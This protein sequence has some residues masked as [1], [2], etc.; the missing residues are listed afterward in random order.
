MEYGLI[1]DTTIQ[2]IADGLREKGIMPK[3]YNGIVPFNFKS[4]NATSLKDPTPTHRIT[5]EEY[6][7]ISIAAAAKIEVIVDVG[8]YENPE[9]PSYADAPIQFYFGNINA[10][11][12]VYPEDNAPIFISPTR[13]DPRQYTCV[14]PKNSFKIGIREQDSTSLDWVALTVKAYALNAEG[15]RIEIDTEETIRYAPYEIVEAINN[16]PPLPP[17]SAFKITGNCNNRFS[18]DGWNWFIN[19]YGDKITTE[20]ITAAQSMFSNNTLERLPFIINLS[21]SCSTDSMFKGC[22]NL[23]EL[24][25][26]NNLS[27]A[28]SLF[29]NCQKLTS[30]N[31]NKFTAIPSNVQFYMAFQS[32]YTL[33][34][35]GNILDNIPDVAPG[36]SIYGFYD[37]FKNCYSLEEATNLPF[38]Y[39]T[40]G[41]NYAFG[42]CFNYCCSIREITFRNQVVTAKVK[43]CTLDLNIF[44]GWIHNA[45]EYIN[46]G[47]SIEKKVTDDASY[48]A[49]K[50]DPEWWSDVPEYSRYNHDSAV[51][52]INSLPDVSGIGIINTIKFK[53]VSGSATDGGAINTL[54][55]EEIAVA[56]AKGWTVTLV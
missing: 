6:I 39:S 26:I 56:T 44:V 13:N 10:D 36:V 48:Q 41:G 22:T 3:Y 18:Y 17:E 52:T 51:N 35:I 30:L 55:A 9:T 19:T 14:I 15:E 33:R 8:Y 20:N 24:P 54:T 46:I 21:N 32:C 31:N 29:Y 45:S 27:P 47:H 49:L 4:S 28:T 11:T 37:T 7:N 34:S 5:A 2:G 42:S 1:K 25:I 40:Y 43:S 16:C 50:N 12:V 38:V 53:G 23:V